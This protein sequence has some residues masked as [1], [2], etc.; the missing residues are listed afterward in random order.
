MSELFTKVTSIGCL[1]VLVLQG[2]ISA[3]AQ[4][5]SATREQ[6]LTD[7]K[8]CMIAAYQANK[9]S[10]FEDIVAECQLLVT[11]FLNSYPEDQYQ[12]IANQIRDGEARYR[13]EN[14]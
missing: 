9:S 12:N 11:G 1:T 2:S 8:A 13:L 3:R 14:P 10:T 7:M 4:E 6:L 5:A